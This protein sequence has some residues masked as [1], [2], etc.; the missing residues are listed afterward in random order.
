[1][2]FYSNKF[3]KKK[4]VESKYK[5]KKVL[6]DGIIFSSKKECDRYKFLKL[7]EE[8]NII[9]DLKTQQV[10]ELIPAIKITEE[11]KLKTKTKLVER[12]IQRAINYVC[13]FSY[14]KNGELIVEDV[15]ASNSRFAIDKVFFIKEKIFRWKYGFFIKKVIKPNE[16]V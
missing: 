6:Y 2:V 4:D 8:Q 11:K 7:M 1:M 15:K 10:F 12:T 13:D 5:N 3:K 9:Q 14:Y 16:E